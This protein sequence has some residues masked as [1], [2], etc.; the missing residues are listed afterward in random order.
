MADWRRLT[1]IGCHCQASCRTANAVPIRQSITIP[2]PIETPFWIGDVSSIDGISR[3]IL[4][5]TNANPLPI[6]AQT[7]RV[8][9]ANPMS[10]G[11]QS[12]ANS[13]SIQ[14]RGLANLVPDPIP[15]A[16]L[17]QSGVNPVPIQCQSKPIRCQSSPNPPPIQCQSGVNP[18]PIQCQSSANP[19][20]IQGQ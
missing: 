17:S 5:N 18:T 3:S 16:N 11:H 20:P 13:M 9:V 1:E 8:S 6:G 15:C 14:C 10:I 12:A 2:I 7:E 4:H 19:V